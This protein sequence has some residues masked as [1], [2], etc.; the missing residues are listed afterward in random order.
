LRST[1]FRSA[2]GAA[3]GLIHRDAVRAVVVILDIAR[4]QHLG[5]P[6]LW[7]HCDLCPKPTTWDGL[8]PPALRRVEPARELLRRLMVP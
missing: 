7:V 4:H 3:I 5:H 2:Y 6:G 1:A 8:A